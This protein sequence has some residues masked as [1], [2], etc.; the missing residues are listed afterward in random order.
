MPWLCAGDFN[1]IAKTHEKLGRRVRP[2]VQMKN[3]G[4]A[5]DECGLM[6]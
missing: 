2:Y 1:E 3:F 6:D 4:D 5:L